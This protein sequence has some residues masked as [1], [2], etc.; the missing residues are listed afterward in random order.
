[1]DTDYK[2]TNAEYRLS[3]I[4]WANE[5]I[6][7]PELCALCEERLG[8]K[9]TTTY[10]VLKKLC[11]RGIMRNESAVVTSLVKREQ[12][13]RYESRAVLEKAFGGSL[14]MFVAAF[15]NGK[16]LS[17]EEAEQL[18]ELIDRHREG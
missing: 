10:T 17:D 16:K 3:D 9:R 7:S 4:I 15:L 5:P 14:P 1:M 8:W 12:A 18:K 2:M 6:G 13:Q 11:E